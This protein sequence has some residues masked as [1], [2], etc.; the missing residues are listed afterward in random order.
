M[1]RSLRIRNYRLWFTGALVSNIG[2]WMQRTAQSWLVFDELTD[3]DATAMG[4]VMAL[5]FVPQLVLAPYAGVLAD[6][7]DRRRILVVTQG[8]MALLAA[9]LGALLLLG[10]AELGTVYG[11]ALALGIVATFDAPVRQTFVSEMVPDT[12]LSNAVALNS[13]SFNSARLI[14]PAVA[15]VLVAAVGTGWVFMLNTLTFAAMIWAILLIDGTRLRPSPRARRARGQIREGVGYVLHRPDLVAVMSTIF[16]IGTFGM[17]FAV[18]LAAMAG[19]V[20][21]QGSEEFGVLNSVLAVGTVTGA[22]LSARRERARLRYVFIGCA[23]FAV[24]CLGAATAPALWLFAVWLVPCGVSSLTIM[25]TANAYVQSTTSPTM[26]GRV[27][28]LYMAIFMGGTPIGAPVVG[29]LTDTLGARWG[30]GS[31][32]LAGLSGALIGAWY[33][34]RHAAPRPGVPSTAS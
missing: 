10:V 27:M 8:V 11:F 14:G 13:T 32:V 3:H 23:A 15:G 19:S 1:F 22:L 30:M 17:N 31:A 7:Y 21:G 4:V 9:A 2:T 26:R 24:S 25:T 12:Y 28:S 29:W 34:W 33:A 18:Y 20:F 6:R 5:Q 16:M